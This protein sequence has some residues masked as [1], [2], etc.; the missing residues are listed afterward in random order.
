VKPQAVGQSGGG[1]GGQGLG[2]RMKA[3]MKVES[4]IRDAGNCNLA[5]GNSRPQGAANCSL[6]TDQ[7]GRRQP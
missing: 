5:T 2:K 7:L 1:R 4:R 3:G 6:L